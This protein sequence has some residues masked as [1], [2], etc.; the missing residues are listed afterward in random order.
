MTRFFKSFSLFS[1]RSKYSIPEPVLKA[2]HFLFSVFDNYTEVK[3]KDMDLIN[4]VG[5]CVSCR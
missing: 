4:D 1:F 5:N 3:G 2:F